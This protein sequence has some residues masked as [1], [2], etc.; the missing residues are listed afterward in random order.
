MVSHGG[1]ESAMD[2]VMA[3]ALAERT[4]TGKWPYIIVRPFVVDL[5]HPDTAKY[6]PLGSDRHAGP[7]E[8]AF[9]QALRPELVHLDRVLEP[10]VEKLQTIPHI[11]RARVPRIRK[12]PLGYTADPRTADVKSGALLVDA[13]ARRLAEVIRAF[14]KFDLEKDC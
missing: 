6:Y 3:N 7:I 5:F 14:K 4:R 8:T 2:D 9:I 10:S 13:A 11:S 1:A 12:T